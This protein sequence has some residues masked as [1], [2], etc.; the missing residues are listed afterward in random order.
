MAFVEASGGDCLLDNTGQVVVEPRRRIS[1]LMYGKTIF[2]IDENISRYQ[3][4][5]G[6]I[7]NKGNTIL[8]PQFDD[9]YGDYKEFAYYLVE[10]DQCEYDYSYS[11][12]AV[13]CFIGADFE[14]TMDFVNLLRY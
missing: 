10:A 6:I 1:Y 9:I 7:D 2:S 12:E 14:Y 3:E 13:P 8:N 11:K 4:K 5:W